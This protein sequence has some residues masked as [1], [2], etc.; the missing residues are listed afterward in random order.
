MATSTMNAIC[1]QLLTKDDLNISDEL[2]DSVQ[3]ELIVT[4]IV[5]TKDITAIKIFS[6]E[7]I[8][9]ST[10]TPIL[11]DFGFEIIDEVTYNI[12]RNKQEVYISRF[13]LD[14]KDS[15]HICNAKENIELV[16]SDTLKNDNLTR[17]QL[18]SLVY[19]ENLSIRKILLLR[20]FI[21]Y[22]DQ[23][24][25]SLS[26]E[27][28]LT[29][30]THHSY[31]AKLFVDY[32]DVKFNPS[33]TKR[34]KTFKSLEAEIEE[35][36][37]QV[38]NI[39]DDRILKLT[40]VFLQSILRTNFFFHKEAIA[41]K[42]DTKTFGQNLKGL[43][44][45]I[46]SFIYHPEFYGIHLRMSN[47]SR[48]GIRWSERH[49]DYRQEVKSLMITQEGKNSI[50]IPDGAKGGFV[51]HKDKTEISKEYFQSM[52][53]QFIDNMLDL[54]DN[55]SDGKVIR[56]EKIMAYDDE[57]TYFVI[58]ADKGTAA[59]SDVA[60]GIAIERNYWLGDAFASGG[61]NGFG[62]K[63]L[64]I[65]ARGAITCT[66]RFFIEEG[67]D[68]DKESV[69]VV[70]IGSMNG[71]VFGNGMLDS[72]E[73]KL[74]AAIGH[75]EIFIDPNPI[76]IVSFEERQRLFL[77]K[78]GS[79]G[80]YHL[81]L[82]SK[83]GGI[84]LRAD[85]A[86]ELSGEMKKMFN[87]TKKTM[88]GEEVCRKI[89]TM[90]VDL[91]FNGGVGTYVKS[92]DESNLYLGDKQNEAVRVDAVD[93]KAR[94]VSEGGNLGFTQ[95]ARIEYAL[96]GGKINIDG[97]DNAA[98]VDTSDHEVNLKILLNTI[99][100]KGILCESESNS[101]LHSLTDQ[102]V[103][104]VLWSNYQ[105][106]LA[107]SKDEI[108]SRKYL[109]DFIYS[110]EVLENHITAFNR[111]DF[112]IPKN[113]LM[114]EVINSEGSIVRPIIS[115]LISYSKIFIKKVLLHST[116]IDETFAFTYL[117]KYFPKAFVAAYEHEIA[118]HPLKR[119]IIATKMAD[120]IV[121]SQ[122]VTFISNY[123][124]IGLEKFLLKIKSYIISSHLFSANDIKYEIYRQDFI[125]PIEEQYRLLDE[126]EHTLNF[127]TRWMVKY[128]TSN[129]VDSVHIL[130]HKIELF[131]ILSSL[132]NIEIEEIIPGNIDFNRFYGVIE[133]L[134][135]AIAVIL[136]TEK[137]HHSFKDV[138]ILFY[139]V[140]SEFKILEMIKALN[141]TGITNKSDYKLKLQ[142]M[143]F[144]EFIVMHY[145]EKLLTF[146]RVN[147]VP[148]EA[149]ENYKK[150][151]QETFDRITEQIENF[152]EK[153]VKDLQTISITI[154]QLMVSII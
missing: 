111:K 141:D 95:K 80:Q 147:E 116:L 2:F 128:L 63:K 89:L 29:T 120:S 34:E 10:I 117:K 139:S 51:I 5:Q 77:S 82:I 37:K 17:C 87:T 74:L 4:K 25:I 125:M 47:I 58:A 101:T 98:G 68:I 22:I 50:I 109:D 99:E 43:Q 38:P 32:F 59:M 31:I 113:E 30:L 136:I 134:R 44:P 78:N 76:P 41:L 18:F 150:N 85:K 84:F 149:F 142:V 151:E 33:I 52:Y 26:S 79:W 14:L 114:S 19:S 1:S 36:I 71:D 54:V 60:N 67:I 132:P 104:L 110:I 131:D 94:I 11:H 46:E 90:K 97:I 55:V 23:A 102:V 130:D 106:A 48:G 3:N 75:K 39:M 135:F 154:N 152:M 42:I 9:L 91:L 15:G 49:E 40:Y 144:I 56:D 107:I 123:E 103:N 45:N 140:L 13:N 7:R 6:K 62:H 153:D 66:K 57:D 138:M 100:D 121:N 96:A 73:F 35:N 122:G 28:I 93:I 124:K 126:L 127:A 86:I 133:Y 119:E 129:Q 143:Q 16:I 70:G 148:E 61:S 112:Y 72:K 24:E 83:G 21:E 118:D 145:T 108:L 8:Y 65:T 64:G 27:S 20:A 115:S 137:T 69:T 81:S 12:E 92:V 146:Q 105:Q 53:C 88:S